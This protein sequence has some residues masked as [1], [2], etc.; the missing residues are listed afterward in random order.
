MPESKRRKDRGKRSRRNRDRAGEETQAKSPLN[1]AEPMD[2]KDLD[3]EDE[4]L[5]PWYMATMV[6]L[7]LLGLFWLVV[8]YI[9]EGLLPIA[10]AGNWNVAIGFGVAMIGFLMTMK[11]R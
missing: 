1:D 8:W 10:A 6:G 4:S 9:S 2:L 5:P 3:L 7:M 11:W